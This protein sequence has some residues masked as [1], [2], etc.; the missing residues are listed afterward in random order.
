MLA[1][2][3]PAYASEVL[4]TA[5]R[6]YMTSYTNMCFIIGQFIS[7]GVLKGLSTRTDQWGYRIPFALQWFWPCFLI[8]LVYLAPESPWYLVR[9]NRLEEAEQSLRRLQSPKATHIN[10]MKTLATIVYT[11][12]LEEQL[13][14]G[15]SYWDCFKGFELRRT[16]IAC[17]VFAGQIL[18]GICFAYNSSYFF[19]NVGIGTSAT[20]SLALGGTALALVGC[21]VNWFGKSPAPLRWYFGTL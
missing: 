18:C 16:E 3:A 1:T 2:T 7:A 17:V 14:V 19:Q 13:S 20:Y 4:P 11:N 6:T 15:T 12:N 10:P 21:F 9:M 8:P 5:L